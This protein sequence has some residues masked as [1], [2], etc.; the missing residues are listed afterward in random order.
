MIRI[1]LIQAP[2]RETEAKAPAAGS[3][4]G[5]REI[6]P[7][8]AF[9]VCLGLV[10]LLY[11]NSNHSISTLTARLA[12]ERKEA[13]RLSVL[14]AQ[15]KR[16]Q[17]QLGEIN[18][19]INVIQTLEKNRTGPRDLMALLGGAADRVNGL[20]FLS[21]NTEKGR[22]NIHGQ[23]DD[24]NRVADFIAALEDAGSFSDVELRRVFED[25]R[26]T[27]VSFKFDLDCLY[28]PPVEVAASSP[29]APPSDGSGRPPGR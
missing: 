28:K 23:S 25:D 11:L 8:A 26:N 20:Y 24:A 5:R 14:E 27:K 12:A 4:K 21:V 18:E 3:L 22:L 1:N 19:H 17:S 10:G 13:S 15:N 7:L 16:Y 6:Y 29:P 9:V 2:S